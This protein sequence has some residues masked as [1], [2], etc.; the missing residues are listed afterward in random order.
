M[1]RASK[2]AGVNL[3]GSVE[4]VKLSEMEGERMFKRY[5]SVM[6]FN[7]SLKALLDHLEIIKP[8]QLLKYIK[9]P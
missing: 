3:K 7:N 2:K 9:V 4:W 6:Q 1:M 8:R 5:Y